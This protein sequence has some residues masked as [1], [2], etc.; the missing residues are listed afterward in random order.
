MQLKPDETPDMVE[1]EVRR[2]T[3]NL[4]GAVGANTINSATVS[5][6]NLTLGSPTI[7]GSSVSFT[8]TASRV[9]TPQSLRWLTSWTPA[10]TR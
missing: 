10:R 1:G 3:L 6:D 5:A 2:V 4:A 7:N 9:G 8:V